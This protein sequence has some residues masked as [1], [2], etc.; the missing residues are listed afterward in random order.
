M[1]GELWSLHEISLRGEKGAYPRAPLGAMLRK[2]NK[3]ISRC[4]LPSLSYSM[5]LLT[6]IKLEAGYCELGHLDLLFLET[7]RFNVVA[8]SLA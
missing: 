2:T 7:D 5:K 4:T 1:S 8:Y 3:A 6:E